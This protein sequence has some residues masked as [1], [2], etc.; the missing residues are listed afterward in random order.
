[1]SRY[2]LGI[3]TWGYALTALVILAFTA[4]LVERERVYGQPNCQSPSGSLFVMVL[5]RNTININGT[6]QGGSCKYGNLSCD[7]AEIPYIIEY[8]AAGW[9]GIDSESGGC[10]VKRTT[11]PLTQ[12]QQGQNST[13]NPGGGPVPYTY[14]YTLNINVSSLATGKHT[15]CVSFVSTDGEGCVCEAF[16]L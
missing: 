4:S 10:P 11:I 7:D 8:T 5:S 6:A 2:I 14:S 12:T 16:T 13:C 1:M 9:Y 3:R 15:M